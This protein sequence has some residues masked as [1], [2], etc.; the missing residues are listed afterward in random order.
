MD[1]NIT[2]PVNQLGYGLVGHNI[3]KSAVARDNRV[4][5]WPIGNTDIEQK[6]V[7]LL[8][9]CR[10]NTNIFNHTAPSLRIYHQFDLAQ[11]I[12]KGKR[13]ALPI[14]ELDTFN[15]IEKCHLSAQNEIVVASQ[16]AKRVI[17][18]NGVDVP[19]HVVPFGVDRDIFNP[20]DVKPAKDG[21]PT[22]FINIGKWEVRKGHDVLVEA[23]CNAFE[24]GDNVKLIMMTFNPCFAD[25]EQIM[26]Y[27]KDWWTMYE[28]CKLADKIQ[29]FKG[30]VRTQR[31]VAKIMAM[32]DCGVFPSR[33]EGWNM[34]LLE[35]MSMGK[36]V[37]ATNCSAH[38]QYCTPANCYLIDMDEKESAYDGIW[39][40][41]Q[42]NWY[43]FEEEQKDQLVDHMRNVHTAK[44]KGELVDNNNGI[45]IAKCLSWDNTV[46]LL[47]E[48]LQ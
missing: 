41:G 25:N 20:N 42:G 29:I 4:A 6:D 5:W 30:R 1:I 9:E 46:Q 3:I 48:V 2:S 28:N 45:E 38:T 36:N 13:V 47:E 44:Q 21:D 17:E 37:I 26:K 12:G 35:M 10:N 31:E 43:E 32:A 40:H 39:F 15:D 19:V 23:F 18:D 11:H 16:W 8:Q 24:K 7:D 14:F 34:E 22:V 33:G 27:N